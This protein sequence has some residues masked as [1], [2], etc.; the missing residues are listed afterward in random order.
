METQRCPLFFACNLIFIDVMILD[1]EKVDVK[2]F[3]RGCRVNS[4]HFEDVTMLF[5][6]INIDRNGRIYFFKLPCLL[7]M[8]R[9]LKLPKL[10][11]IF[12]EV[13]LSDSASVSNSRML[14]S[15]DKPAETFMI[16]VV[17]NV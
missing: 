16:V 1:E 11:L 2:V 14:G 7:R 3:G 17:F 12:E 4:D 15:K 8:K 9:K 13:I 6:S 5:H 10:E